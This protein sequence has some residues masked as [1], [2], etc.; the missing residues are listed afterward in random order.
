MMQTLE[1]WY[2]IKVFFEDQASREVKF[3]G[4]L[5]RYENFSKVTE[6]LEMTQLAQFRI[7]GNVVFISNG[8]KKKGN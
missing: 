4:N 1:R 6:L 2:D 3:T 7:K 5:K 8:T